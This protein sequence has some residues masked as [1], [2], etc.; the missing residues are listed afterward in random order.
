VAAN[1]KRYMKTVRRSGKAWTA[2][3]IVKTDSP[4]AH[5]K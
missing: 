1:N 2:Q 3:G 5:L 4:T